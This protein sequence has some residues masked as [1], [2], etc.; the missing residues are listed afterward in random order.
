[1]RSEV[2]SA[3]IRGLSDKSKV[4]RDKLISFWSD[5]ARLSMD[6]VERI[7]QLM[8]D[9]YVKEEENIWLNN[10]VFLLMQVSTQSS[11]YERKIF[12]QPLQE[13]KFAPLNINNY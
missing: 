6:A 5:A 10:A 1:M 2:K 4:V 13:C 3:L 9:L 12:D 7:K 11:D 8:N